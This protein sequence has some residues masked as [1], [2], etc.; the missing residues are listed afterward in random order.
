[1][2]AQAGPSRLRRLNESVQT[3]GR[4]QEA[5]N[6]SALAA[7][8]SLQDIDEFEGRHRGNNDEGIPMT[9]AELA[10][11]LFFEDARFNSDRAMA[12]SLSESTDDALPIRATPPRNPVEPATVPNN[13]AS[14]ATGF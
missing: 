9:D 10:L 14:T 13:R 4:S 5:E 8:L 1:M 12:L 2:S 6:L 11:S 3:N 7:R